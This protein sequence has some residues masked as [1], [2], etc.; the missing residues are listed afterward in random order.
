MGERKGQNKYYP[1]DYDPKKGGLKFR[2]THAPENGLGKS[3]WTK[4][5]ELKALK[6]LDDKLLAK[7]SLDIALLPETQQDRQ[8]AALMKLQ[9]K[10]A[11]EREEEKRID[12]L[13]QPAIPGLTQTTFGGLKRQKLSVPIWITNNWVLKEKLTKII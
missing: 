2:G 1:P 13:L 10:S 5:H 12:I 7:S 6:D 8:M 11:Q 9:S 4:K 3:T